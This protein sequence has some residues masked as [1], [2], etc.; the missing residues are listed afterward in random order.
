MRPKPLVAFFALAAFAATPAIASIGCKGAP[1]VIVSPPPPPDPPQ[2]LE[3]IDDD[4]A[5]ALQRAKAKQ[6]PIFVEAWAPWCHTCLSMRAFV[7]G[8]PRLV[9]ER[10]RFVWL[11]IDT[12]QPRNASFVEKF[13]LE[14]WPTLW[15][16]DPATERPLLKWVGSATA[17][18]LAELLD[19]VSSGEANGEA[20]AAFLR[21]SQAAAAGRAA[22]AVTEYRASLG[23]APVDWP[24]RPRVV[25]ALTVQLSMMGD[26]A[27]CVD[28]AIKELPDLPPGSSRAEVALTALACGESLPKKATQRADVPT[29]ADIVARMAG[30]LNQPIL[31]DSRSELYSQL[32]DYRTATGD[33]PG[34]K[35]AATSW[36]KF[37]EQEA[38]S[39]PTSAARA[40]FDT[41]RLSA[42]LALG[43]VDKAIPMLQQSERD[44]PGDYNPPARLAR[45]QLELGHLDD[46]LASVERALSKVYGPRK[47]RILALKADILEKQGNKSGAK[48]VLQDA[49]KLGDAMT[50]SGGYAKL[51]VELKKRAGA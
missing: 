8:D 14:F 38:A 21:G 33:L 3:F 37:L 19:D 48:L 42:Y 6:R 18:E 15:V 31:A 12:E 45:A 9:A 25:E 29:L 44:F 49:V 34:A 17:I 51:L 43:Q 5:T 4:Y 36:A 24:K 32:V 26:A 7:F 20:G 40:V 50:L 47:L 35:R 1:P 16:I 41:D 10:D 22:D 27:G 28:L 13:P 39:A 46:A 2:K 23:A 30:D 11:S